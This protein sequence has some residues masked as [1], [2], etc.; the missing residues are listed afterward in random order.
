[1]RGLSRLFR[2]PLGCRPL[3][4][5]SCLL[6]ATGAGADPTPAP[7]FA[8][9]GSGRPVADY[10]VTLPTSDG[11]RD[12]RVPGDCP[13]ILGHYGEGSADRSRVVGR[14]LWLKAASDCRY[15]G[16][17]HRHDGDDPVDHVSDVDFRA[18]DLE[19]LPRA[20]HCAGFPFELCRPAAASRPDSRPLFAALPA[21]FADASPTEGVACRLENGR[22]LAAVW[23]NG[24]GLYCETRSRGNVRLLGVDYADLNGDG[25]LDAMLRLKLFSP[26][27]GRRSIHLPLTR[28]ESDGPLQVPQIAGGVRR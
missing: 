5:A 4:L 1:M 15:F 6:A 12:Y 23:R 16:I 14:R 25:I 7:L 13:Q 27:D 20:I 10:A 21:R 9:P 17:L 22:L 26:E 28:L 2:N 3:A 18:L 11:S 24:T 19:T 8:E